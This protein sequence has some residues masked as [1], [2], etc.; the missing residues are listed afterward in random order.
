MA[1]TGEKSLQYQ[2]AYRKANKE[3]LEKDRKE[4]IQEQRDYIRALKEAT[5]CADCG[6]R[7]SYW[8]MQFDHVR[9]EKKYTLNRLGK[10]RVA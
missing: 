8:I 1:L 2:R 4:R 9:G 6:Q 7:Y 10:I 5:P 3:R